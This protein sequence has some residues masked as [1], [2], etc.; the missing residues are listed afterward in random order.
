[1]ASTREAP[2]QVQTEV[3]AVDLRSELLGMLEKVG[4]APPK[5]APAPRAAAPAAAEAARPAKAALTKAA[6]AKVE[7][8]PVDPS[9]TCVKCG[10]KDPWGSASWCPKC[11]Y[12]PGIGHEGEIPQEETDGLEN[13]TFFD[14]CP[15]WA[16]QIVGGL[17]VIVAG[18]FVMGNRLDGNV[19]WL[20]LA[21][22]IQLSVGCLLMLFAH[23]QAI[24]MS[25]RDPQ[26]PGIMAL[27]TYP[28]SV[29]F[30][31]LQHL[32]ERAYLL[33]TLT[34]G[35]CASAMALTLYGPIHFS[36]IKKEVAESKKDKKSFMGKILGTMAQVTAVT[37]GGDNVNV[38][39][40]N[41]GSLEDAIGGFAGLATEQG[42][43]GDVI[44]GSGGTQ[45]VD[46]DAMMQQA[47]NDAM[48][49]A[50]GGGGAGPGGVALDP[51]AMAM[52]S[53]GGG[54]GGSDSL[55]GAIGNFADVAIGQVGVDD[56]EQ[57]AT[58]MTGDLTGG[59]NGQ[60]DL[61]QRGGSGT[62]AEPTQQPNRTTTPIAPTA[63]GSTTT[64]RT[65]PSTSG[66]SP[67]GGSGRNSSSGTAKTKTDFAPEK[68][69]QAVVFGYLMS[70]GGEIR[71]L[72]IATVGA[73]GR[74]RFAGKLSSDAMTQTEWQKLVE[75]LPKLR[76]Q[77]PLVA[78]PNA[79][80]WVAPKYLL[81]IGTE[82]WT[83]TGPVDAQVLSIE[84]R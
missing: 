4:A 8:A 48:A 64:V 25:L 30:P 65:L 1:M 81:D 69:K 75:E 73:D 15:P 83:P 21:S 72:L 58:M 2:E 40:G 59:T 36:E 62:T 49:D 84:Q 3:N 43:L 47:A 44:N 51:A 20:S 7:D 74:P 29:W 26:C 67:S 68:I 18:T 55:D 41:S 32:K 34:W 23:K 52:A 76:T 31:V 37:Q 56:P 10:N 60:Q 16:L 13:L 45:N 22:L 61:K 28:P 42:G 6:A 70:A 35:L 9:V 63:S 53:G 5:P 57:L 33:V 17:I 14:L 19:G 71:T 80:Y 78:C 27:I 46:V 24:M 54:G 50:T 39:V 12:Y 77:R 79:G 82:R 11:G 66:K 38:N